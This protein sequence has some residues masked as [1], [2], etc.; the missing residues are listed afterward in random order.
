MA[1]IPYV[2]QIR[3][4][5]RL[6][7]GTVKYEV[8]AIITDRGDL[9]STDLFVLQIVD[10]AAPKSDVLARVATPLELKQTDPS[11]PLYVKVVST[12]ITRIEGDTFARI[13]NVNDVTALPR[14][15]VVAVREGQTLYLGSSLTL[16]YDNITTA[17][18]AYRQLNARLSAL[19]TEWRTYITSFATTPSQL[20]ALPIV[21][22][23][24][25]AER[26]ALYAT[27][28]KAR[29]Q[30]ESDRDAAKLAKE[31]CERDCAAD[32]TIY[33]YLVRDVAFLENARRIVITT[34][35]TAGTVLNLTGGT[36]LTPPGTYSIS[37]LPNNVVKTFVTNA[38]D[39]TSYQSLLNLKTADLAVYQEKVRNCAVTC[40]GLAA[41]LLTAE[42]IVEAARSAENAALA[43]VLSVCPTFD[44]STV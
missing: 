27:R 23:S 26:T 40:A 7:D 34:T 37:Y 3:R 1:L 19:V 24:E 20:Y 25:E 18:A 12:D 43:S 33:D 39:S 2:K 44:S 10:P 21:D 22:A 14:D 17:D 6:S 28:K 8:T 41:A 38:A 30:A 32:K 4:V 16:I 9:P 5:L 35:E 11:S 42:Q 29:I 15:R 36:T 13:A 31:A